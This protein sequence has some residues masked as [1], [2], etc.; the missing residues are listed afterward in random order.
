MEIIRTAK[1]QIYFQH[2][3]NIELRDIPFYTCN[4]KYLQQTTST[5]LVHIHVPWISESPEVKWDRELEEF[6]R[7]EQCCQNIINQD[8]I[9]LQPSIIHAPQTQSNDVPLELE[10]EEQLSLVTSEHIQNQ[11]MTGAAQLIPQPRFNL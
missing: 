7:G 8:L 11:S 9:F 3:I 2:S 6:L 10:A 1:Q 5:L 4:V